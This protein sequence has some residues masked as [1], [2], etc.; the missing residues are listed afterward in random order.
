MNSRPTSQGDT[1]STSGSRSGSKAGTLPRTETIDSRFESPAGMLGSPDD[2]RLP[3]ISEPSSTDTGY[4]TP[5]LRILGEQ[6]LQPVQSSERNVEIQEARPISSSQAVNQSLRELVDSRIASPASMFGGPADLQLFSIREYRSPIAGY[7]SRDFNLHGPQFLE[8]VHDQC[9]KMDDVKAR[10]EDLW[11]STQ[12]FWDLMLR[13]Q[14]N[15]VTSDIQVLR[16]AVDLMLDVVV[17][18]MLPQLRPEYH[19]V[20]AE[21]HLQALSR[22]LRALELRLRTDMGTCGK[23]PKMLCGCMVPIKR[24]N[25]KDKL[26][27]RHLNIR[28]DEKGRSED[29]GLKFRD[30]AGLLR[31]ED[32]LS[33]VYNEFEPQLSPSSPAADCGIIHT[34]IALMDDDIKKF[35]PKKDYNTADELKAEWIYVLCHENFRSS[36]VLEAMGIVRDAVAFSE[37][38]GTQT[39]REE[40]DLWTPEAIP[41]PLTGAA[42]LRKL[43]TFRPDA[44]RGVSPLHPSYW[45][46]D[47][48]SLENSSMSRGRK[49]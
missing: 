40:C 3:D 45:K 43:T 23:S 12:L 5:D 8:K 10:Y 27:T 29:R 16:T 31:L 1:P 32:F 42:R 7:F 37:T 47:S 25:N 33:H 44:N 2:S 30:L 38:N 28:K 9:E 49:D 46:R 14:P 19:P 13:M 48:K 15:C 34:T 20:L 4:F 24:P 35:I 21:S 41:E 11:L 36:I 6:S 18:R 26:W 22:R 39:H 17:G